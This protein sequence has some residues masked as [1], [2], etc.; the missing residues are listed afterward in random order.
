MSPRVYA[1]ISAVTRAF[2]RHGIA[3]DRLNLA[4][5]YSY[6]SIDDVVMR[7]APLLARHRLCMLPRALE[8]TASE[9]HGMAGELLLSVSVRVAYDLVCTQDGSSHTIE[10]YG[11]ALDASD[12]ATAK[13]M[14]SAYK[15][16]VLQAFAIPVSG[17]EDADAKSP[18]FTQPALPTEPVQG[19]SQWCEDITAMI[20]GCE[21]LDAV[22][23]VQQVHRA[24]FASLQ[25]ERAELYARVGKAIAGKRAALSRPCPE[26]G[27]TDAKARGPAQ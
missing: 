17:T 11:E 23:R 9:R 16:A 19:W 20:E 8:R 6:R 12:K 27:T 14:Q 21:T 5:D 15:Y 7:L 18:R 13:A 1:A 4:E 24:T 2:A 10:S 25:R 3:K 26:Y 22:D